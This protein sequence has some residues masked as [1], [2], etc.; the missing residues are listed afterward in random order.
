MLNN[1][2]QVTKNILILNI[3]F[4]VATIFLGSQGI[5]LKSSFGIHAPNS[6]LFEPYQVVTHFFMHGDFMHLFFNMF[7]IV[8]FGSHLERVWGAKRFFIF[9]VIAAI[10]AVI[11]TG[12]INFYE[13]SQ[14]QTYLNAEDIRVLNKYI[15]SGEFNMHTYGLNPGSDW[16]PIFEEN[17]DRLYDN[18]KLPFDAISPE[19]V[20]SYK[21][22]YQN[23]SILNV[24]WSVG[25]SGALMGLLAGFVILFPNTEL[26]IIFIP[27]PIKAKY[28]IGAYLAY[29]F[30]MW[31]QGTADGIDYG[32]H[33][34]GAI[35][36]VITVLYWRKTDRSNFW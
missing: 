11:F 19:Q 9:Y 5:D 13:L 23:Y 17:F 31:Y 10:G 4:F 2:P 27:I 28:L 30:I 12:V 8:I 33:V 20:D 7:G 15:Q 26:M 36:G 22:I 16:P 32:A 34:G 6:I 35:A 29:Q 18:G 14:I 24:R 3:V 25:A 1:L 21:I